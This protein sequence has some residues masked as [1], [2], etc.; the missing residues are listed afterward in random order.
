MK[1][2]S[3]VL[4][5]ALIAFGP[6]CAWASFGLDV[7]N[8]T[9]RVSD[10]LE[11]VEVYTS[12]QRSA[13]SYEQVGD[14]LRAEFQVVLQIR[15]SGQVAMSDTFD[16]SDMKV[17][18]LDTFKTADGRDTTRAAVSSGQF[19]AH[20]FRLVMKPGAYGLWASLAQKDDV[21]DIVEDTLIVPSLGGNEL[22]LSGFELGTKLDFD[23]AKSTFVKNG[24]RLIPNPT[25]FFGTQL[26]MLYYYAEAY[27]LDF[28]TARV[29]SY[30]V[31]RRVIDAESG[32]IARPEVQKSFSNPASSVVLAD[33]FPITTLRT[34]TYYLELEVK[35]VRS[36]RT[37][38]GRK[39]FWAYRPEDFAAGRVVKPDAAYQSR[40]AEVAPDFLEVVDADSALQWMRYILTKQQSDQ[41]KRLTSD[42][43]REFLR[44][45]WL[46]QERVKAG[47][48]NRYF[49]RVTEANRRY[50]FLKRPGWR[51][52]RG[53]VFILYGEPERTQR[54]YAT[55]NLP[56][57]EVW[58]YDQLDGGAV[59]VFADRSGFGDLDLVHSTKRGEIYNPNWY[60]TT[61]SLRRSNDGT[62]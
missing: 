28:D 1:K 53:R 17:V 57:H 19:F 10:T 59:F 47:E 36:G 60:Q 16:A 41:V 23:Q 25:R 15:D 39:K 50:S 21:R 43:K 22:Q 30:V 56:D 20:I 9:F 5:L 2:M 29:D 11:Y 51:T 33:G 45:Y 35:C 62:Q 49:A 12:V 48:G 52:D 46:E 13:L 6:A 14:S 55:S 26:P 8:A 31:S 3:L 34:G 54:N 7:D 4:L 18:V 58:E 24:I 40:M 44:N 61:P 27:G 37:A 42:G 38:A 32:N